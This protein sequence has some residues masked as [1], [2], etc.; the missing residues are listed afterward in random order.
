[1][2]TEKLKGA[3]VST[4]ENHYLSLCL[5]N[6]V[7]HTVNALMY[8]QDLLIN[9]DGSTPLLLKEASI[10]ESSTFVQ[11]AAENIGAQEVWLTGYYSN[12]IERKELFGYW[13]NEALA[14]AGECRLF[15]VFQTEYAELGIVVATTKRGQGV[16]TEVLK[17]LVQKANNKGL[18][19]ICSTES[20]NIAAQK[21][22]TKAGFTAKNRIV[23][24]EF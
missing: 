7:S 20:S 21:A 10:D 19:S 3:C 2:A 1:M 22:I 6:A 14:A 24:V 23:Q 13:Q 15:D 12:L 18:K 9:K 11:F 8:Q 5:D 16:A 17:L 4:A